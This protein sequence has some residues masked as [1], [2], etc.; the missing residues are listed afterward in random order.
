MNKTT[1]IIGGVIVA[2]ILG[3]VLTTGSKP[4][5]N[6]VTSSN[7]ATQQVTQNT[8]NQKDSD[9]DGL[10]D[11]AEVLLGTDPMNPDTNGNGINDKD[12]PDPI[13][14]SAPA[15]TETET[16]NTPTETV[17]KT[18]PTATPEP[19]PVPAPA[20]VND[21][22]ITSVLV[23][24]N[25]NPAT[26]KDAPDHLEILLRNTGTK[27]ITDFSL[28]YTITDLVT[29]ATQSYTVPLTG[30]VLKAG[31]STS[32]HVDVSGDPGH[33]RANPNSLYYQSQNEMRVDVTVSSPSHVTQ[34]GTVKKDAGGAEL[35]D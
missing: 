19:T 22:K 7:A 18:E 33:F 5:T 25:V 17:T 28:Y 11:N 23:E 15:V 29:N 8:D 6:S 24:N 30:F 31:A 20:P 9:G 14:A 21:F 4:A 2:L 1:I 35:P 12:D 32:V 34:T 13:N 26:G 10:P 3:V 27:D 16:T